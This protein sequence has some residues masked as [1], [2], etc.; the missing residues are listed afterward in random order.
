MLLI[1]SHYHDADHL[2]SSLIIIS[3]IVSHFCSLSAAV[4]IIIQERRKRQIPSHSFHKT[5]RWHMTNLGHFGCVFRHFFFLDIFCPQCCF[6]LRPK[7]HVGTHV[8]PVV[9][10]IS[11]ALFSSHQNGVILL[12]V[13][14]PYNYSN[15]VWDI[16]KYAA[17]SPLFILVSGT[18]RKTDH[19]PSWYLAKSVRMREDE[20]LQNIASYS[21]YCLKCS[22]EAC[23]LLWIGHPIFQLREYQ[24]EPI[25]TSKTISFLLPWF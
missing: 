14:L 6:L 2:W 15:T 18:W 20:R 1:I 3:I 22:I 11:D 25:T 8:P 19:K 24:T 13:D 5:S 12:R 7:S 16:L 9:A 10:S 4:V 17:S 23:G 21:I